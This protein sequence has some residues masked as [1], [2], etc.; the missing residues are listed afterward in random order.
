[1]MRPGIIPLITE[2]RKAGLR[3][4][5]ATTTTKANVTALLDGA[6]SGTGHDWFEIIAC[7]EDAPIKKPNPQVYEYVLE[8]LALPAQACLAI[9][10]SYNGA[11]ATVAAH[12]PV[13]ITRSIYT[14]DDDVSGALAIFPDL[15]N[16][17]LAHL[18]DLH[19]QSSTK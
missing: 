1:M 13:I 12:I 10:D 14:D 9:E 19:Q 2:A 7:A 5:I 8:K 4:A 3:L 6:T 18:Q 11:R 16:V 17:S 15:S